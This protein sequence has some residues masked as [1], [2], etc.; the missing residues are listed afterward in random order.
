MGTAR[1][2]PCGAR[3]WL[4]SRASTCR[5]GRSAG[6][7]E[8]NSGAL[9]LVNA[10]GGDRSVAR[11]VAPGACK[12]KID[13]K[14]IAGGIGK[15][16]DVNVK[17]ASGAYITFGIRGGLVQSGVHVPGKGWRPVTIPTRT[18][19]RSMTWELS[20]SQAAGGARWGA[21]YRTDDG[22]RGSLTLGRPNE[23]HFA[24]YIKAVGLSAA[25]TI[26][27]VSRGR[28]AQMSV[29]HYEQTAGKK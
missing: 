11:Q 2:R 27:I 3:A 5:G 19:S 13:L 25:R 14:N 26:E 20:L 12:V 9:D 4:S 21:S 16:Y 1:S 28:E 23:V 6:G 8:F 17:E 18:T 29:D 10:R 15:N 24:A 22:K 7:G